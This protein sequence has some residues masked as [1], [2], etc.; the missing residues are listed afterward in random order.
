MK[1]IIT[2]ILIIL[3]FL[4]TGCKSKINKINK[5]FE[6]FPQNTNFNLLTGDEL[7]MNGIRSNKND[8]QYEGKICNII[9]LDEYGFYGYTY[10]ESTR[11][12]N[13]LVGL[14]DNTD[15]IHIAV[16]CSKTLPEKDLIKAGYVNY[17]FYFLYNKVVKDDGTNWHYDR[18]YYVVD[19]SNGYFPSKIVK[20]E[21]F[22]IDIYQTSNYKFDYHQSALRFDY[23][24]VTY[25]GE[26]KRIDRKILKN[27]K[28]GKQLQ[29]N[30]LHTMHA[31]CSWYEK[32][33]DIYICS[34]YEM[35][36]VDE[37]YYIILKWNF[38][39]EACEFFSYIYYEKYP[40]WATALCIL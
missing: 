39:T 3:L 13:L 34:L 20:K 40:E 1:K 28:E 35:G 18:Y 33:G 12:L 7:I 26:T 36:F 25:N 37:C 2:V 23:L 16:F 19:V 38:E 6:G 24:D 4:L 17:H 15:T 11:I 8:I 29:K 30:F 22:N 14:I 9:S 5:M 10:D 31:I 32:D 21:D 27:L